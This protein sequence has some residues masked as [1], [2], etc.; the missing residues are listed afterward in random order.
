MPGYYRLGQVPAKRH[1]QF[2]LPDGQLCAEEVFGTEGF[3][4]NYSILYHLA[5]PAQARRIES[6]GSIAP[7]AWDASGH[8]HHHLHTTRLTPRG[9]PV[10]GRVPLLFNDQVTISLV[11]P[12]EPQPYFYRNGTHDE[13]L[14]VHEGEGTLATQL[15][16]IAFQEGDY[17]YVPRGTTQQVRLAGNRGRLLVI[18]ADGQIDTPRRYR[19][20]HGQ[21][22]EHAPYWERDFRKPERLGTRHDTGEGMFEIRLKILDQLYAYHVDHH[23]FDVIGWDGYLYPYAFSIHDFEPRAGRLHVPPPTHQTFE[24]PGFVVCSFVPR[25][26]DWDPDAVPI[27]YFHSNIDSDEVLY[28][29]DGDYGARKVEVGSITLH[30]RGWAHGPSTGAVEASLGRPRETNELAVMVDTFRPLRL[31]AAA[32]EIDDP[33][34]LRSWDS[35]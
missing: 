19:N 13:L 24:G 34:Y 22:L 5:L 29:V 23:P 1:V 4:G 26:L 2:R 16:E 20:D 28:Y 32:A 14:F 21:L 18:E 17:L 6:L 31:A 27:P 30:P 3:G 12:A 15:G 7:Q 10:D 8:C 11:A 33:G 25:K 35:A 9:N